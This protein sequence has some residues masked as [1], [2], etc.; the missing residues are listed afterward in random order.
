MKT[1]TNNWIPAIM[2]TV[3]AIVIT[4]LIIYLVNTPISHLH[5]N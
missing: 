2:I 4:M 3:V 1:L 5:L